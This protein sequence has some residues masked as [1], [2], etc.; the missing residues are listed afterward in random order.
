MRSDYFIK[1][2]KIYKNKNVLLVLGKVYL[3]VNIFLNNSSVW[4]R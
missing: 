2:R 3:N 1:Y 4:Y